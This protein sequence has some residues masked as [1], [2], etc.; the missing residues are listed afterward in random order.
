MDSSSQPFYRL[1]LALKWHSMLWLMSDTLP[2]SAKNSYSQSPVSPLS[3]IS[4]STYNKRGD[5]PVLIPTLPELVTFQNFWVSGGTIHTSTT[6]AN[7]INI[8]T[9]PS[10]PSFSS[11]SFFFVHLLSFCLYHLFLHEFFTN[12]LDSYNL[13]YTLVVVQAHGSVCGSSCIGFDLWSSV[14]PGYNASFP[15]VLAR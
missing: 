11:C 10:F 4:T 15:G 6:P 2:F 7:T 3:M 1:D 9:S 12:W 8:A 5:L 14:V 13:W